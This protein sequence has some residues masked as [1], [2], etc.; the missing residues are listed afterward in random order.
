MI[1]WNFIVKPWHCKTIS[2]ALWLH[3][4]STGGG[5]G[6]WWWDSQ[7]NDCQEWR[8]IRAVHGLSSSLSQLQIKKK[9]DR[10]I[11]ETVNEFPSAHGSGPTP[12][13]SPQPEKK[14][15]SDGGGW[16]AQ[17]DPERWCRG[18][19]TDLRRGGGEN[20]WPRL[21]TTQGSWLQWF[22]DWETVAKGQMSWW[23]KIRCVWEKKMELLICLMKTIALSLPV[24]HWGG[25]PRGHRRRSA[26]QEDIQKAQERQ[27]PWRRPSHSLL[28][29][30]CQGEGRGRE[31]S[32]EARSAPCWEALSQ[33]S[34][35][36]QEDEESHWC[37]HQI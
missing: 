36:H 34:V 18:G 15:P 2:S 4:L 16:H 29:Q 22:S 19:K 1:S 12:W 7:S 37:R 24:G 27:R 35:P 9:F 26:P 25:E 28:Q 17:L 23:L 21:S 13:R 31:K 6:P 3:G 8:G 33:S 11:F 14:T 5:W 20:V 30:S 32:K 10:K